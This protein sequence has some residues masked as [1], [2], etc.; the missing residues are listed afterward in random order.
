MRNEAEEGR[1]TADK[2]LPCPS[3]QTEHGL[4]SVPVSGKNESS[5]FFLR[6]RPG[7]SEHSDREDSGSGFPSPDGRSS[8]SRCSSQDPEALRTEAAGRDQTERSQSVYKLMPVG[9]TLHKEE[10]CETF[11]ERLTR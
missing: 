5:S 8:G 3:G 9:M 4:L 1:E 10:V 7:S 11:R 2:W 6:F